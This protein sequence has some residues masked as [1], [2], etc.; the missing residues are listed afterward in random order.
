MTTQP[1][2]I[3]LSAE[4]NV[5]VA[6]D[7]IDTGKMV[8]GVTAAGRV[9]KGHKMATRPIAEG[10]PIVFL[11]WEPHPMNARFQMTY[12]PGGDEIF[13][14]YARYLIAYLEQSLKAATL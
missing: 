4:D 11:G 2:F 13:G 3:R 12:L 8:D 14:G 5:V 9:M 1:R 7:M 6:V 10:E